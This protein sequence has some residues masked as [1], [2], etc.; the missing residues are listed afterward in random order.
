MRGLTTVFDG[1]E[2]MMEET[3]GRSLRRFGFQPMTDMFRSFSGDVAAPVD[4][5][6]DGKDLVLRSEL[7]GLKREEI[8]ITI[9][10]NLLVISGEKRIE[11]KT[12]RQGYLRRETSYGTFSR[13]VALPEGVDT[14]KV[15]AKLRDGVLEIRMPKT[16]ETGMRHITVQ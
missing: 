8:D 13:S 15:T 10:G 1:M 12:E 16:G 5:F 7:P 4:V 3:F 11:G 6:E 2:R 9:T 14:G